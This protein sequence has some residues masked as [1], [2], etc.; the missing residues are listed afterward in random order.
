MCQE[1]PI[2]AKCK[3]KL[4]WVK[5]TLLCVVCDSALL[6]DLNTPNTRQEE[7]DWVNKHGKMG[8]QK[9]QGK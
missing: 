3:R 2:C 5:G 8:E 9:P 1:E 7:I 4:V 6:W